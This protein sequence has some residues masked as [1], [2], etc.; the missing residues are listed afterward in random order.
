M[1]SADIFF[2]TDMEKPY[3]PTKI[4]DVPAAQCK[5]EVIFNVGFRCNAF[6]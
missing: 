4:L 6:Y 1:K 2:G 5:K 3:V